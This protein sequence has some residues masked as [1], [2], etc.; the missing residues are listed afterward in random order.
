[1]LI[2]RLNQLKGGLS[3]SFRFSQANYAYLPLEA[4]RKSLRWFE[5]WPQNFNHLTLLIQPGT[6]KTIGDLIL[7]QSLASHKLFPTIREALDNLNSERRSTPRPKRRCIQVMVHDQSAYVSI[8]FVMDVTGCSYDIAKYWISKGWLGVVTTLLRKNGQ[9]E[10]LIPKT[11]VNKAL[12]IIKGTSSVQELSRTLGMDARSLRTLA[13]NQVL[14]PTPYGKGKWN[15]RLSPSEVFALANGLLGIAKKREASL[16][17]RISIDD[18][19]SRLSVRHPGLV[20]PLITALVQCH[21]PLW[22]FGHQ[23]ISFAELAINPIDLHNWRR[24]MRACNH[25]K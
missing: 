5:A 11:S 8:Q 10:H 15:I 21:I 1:M 19:I 12:Q 13:R 6:G 18:A 24:K 7:G 22:F 20:K 9:I 2:F 17:G 3:K 25:E 14:L 16:D 23:P 4:I